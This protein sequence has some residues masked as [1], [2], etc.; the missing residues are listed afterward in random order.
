MPACPPNW[1]TLSR[2]HVQRKAHPRTK[3]QNGMHCPVEPLAESVSQN[4]RSN[5]DAISKQAASGK[6]VP[7]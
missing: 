5:W 3:G 6:R 2:W 1:D 4:R 7:F